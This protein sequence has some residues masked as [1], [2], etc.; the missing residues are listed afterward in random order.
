MSPRPILIE[1]QLKL[2]KKWHICS[3]VNF[4]LCFLFQKYIYVLL[5]LLENDKILVFYISYVIELFLSTFFI[6][7]I[8]FGENENVMWNEIKNTV[9]NITENM[10]CFYVFNSI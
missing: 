4:L 3:L 7:S 10:L 5:E 1:T 9:G 8:L 2:L 6:W